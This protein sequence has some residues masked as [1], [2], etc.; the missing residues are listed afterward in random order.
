[1][2]KSVIIA[3]RE[4][5]GDYLSQIRIKKKISKYQLIKSV[6]LRMEIIDAIEKGSS[7]YTIDSFFKYLT[8]IGVYIFFGDKSGKKNPDDPLD[9]DDMLRQIQKNDPLI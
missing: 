2:E 6:D 8:G 3:A 5:I 9:L 7:A 1:M 4:V